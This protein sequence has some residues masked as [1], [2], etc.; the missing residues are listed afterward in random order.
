MQCIWRALSTHWHIQHLFSFKDNSDSPFH[1]ATIIIMYCVFCVSWT[2]VDIDGE[3]VTRKQNEFINSHKI[4]CV[5]NFNGSPIVFR[6]ISR[7]CVHTIYNI[8]GPPCALYLCATEKHFAHR[9][10]IGHAKCCG[11]HT[12]HANIFSIWWCV[13]PLITFLLMMVLGRIGAFDVTRLPA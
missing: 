4:Y 10:W 7:R 3:K 12:D 13:F 9:S 2:D 6:I 8:F 11:D 5:E 1:L